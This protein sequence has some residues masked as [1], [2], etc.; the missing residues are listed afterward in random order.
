M[1]PDFLLTLMA[2]ERGFEPLLSLHLLSV[3]ET[4]PFNRLGIPPLK[5]ITQQN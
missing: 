1:R 4:D 5:I 3:F 2:E